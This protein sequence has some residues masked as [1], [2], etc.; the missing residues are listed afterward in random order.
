MKGLHRYYDNEWRRDELRRTLSV[1]LLLWPEQVAALWEYGSQ[2]PNLGSTFQ[3]LSSG[4]SAKYNLQSVE[5]YDVGS[6][7]ARCRFVRCLND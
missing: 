5:S 1:S 4:E 2:N 6:S 3:L 7:V